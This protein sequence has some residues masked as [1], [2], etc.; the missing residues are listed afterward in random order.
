MPLRTKDDRAD[1]DG[2]AAARTEQLPRDVTADG[3]LLANR[4]PN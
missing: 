3:G 4:L 1:Y 2:A